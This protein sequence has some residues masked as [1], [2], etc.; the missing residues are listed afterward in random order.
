MLKCFALFRMWF[1]ELDLVTGTTLWRRVCC[2]PCSLCLV[3][4]LLP[5]VYRT[6]P[7]PGDQSN[8]DGLGLLA[9]QAYT[10]ASSRL[11]SGPLT[12]LIYTTLG[13]L[14]VVSQQQ[15]G[16]PPH[17]LCFHSTC[18]MREPRVQCWQPTCGAVLN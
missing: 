13:C 18:E 1:P 16:H 3:S 5:V 9:V 10:F 17:N 14:F 7:I 6:L 12:K 11:F 8:G 2:S 15:L 4:F